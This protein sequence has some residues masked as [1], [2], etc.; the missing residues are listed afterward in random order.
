MFTRRRKTNKHS[1]PGL[2]TT[3]VTNIVLELLNIG[4]QVTSCFTFHYKKALTIRE[5]HIKLLNR[6]V[7][8]LLP[9]DFSSNADIFNFSHLYEWLKLKKDI[10]L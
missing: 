3:I 9:R 6:C 1:S 4:R 5:Y 2:D 10:L 8:F 7:L